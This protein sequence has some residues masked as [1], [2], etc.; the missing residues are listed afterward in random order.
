M[1]SFTISGRT[2]AN[3]ATFRA[4]LVTEESAA[5]NLSRASLTLFLTPDA[6]LS[7]TASLRV[8]LGDVSLSRRS[9]IFGGAGAEV[10]LASMSAVVIPHGIDGSATVS[11]SLSLTV[12]GAAYAFTREV[13][14]P[15]IDRASRLTS[16]RALTL[17]ETLRVELE[18]AER[19][20]SHVLLLSLGDE[21]LEWQLPPL[22]E[23]E[24]QDSGGRIRVT[25]TVPLALATGLTDA[26]KGEGTL[27]LY[28]HYGNAD[29]GTVQYEP[30]T[31]TV[32][33][34][35]ETIPDISLTAA[36]EGAP[37]A[38]SGL[39]IEGKTRVRTGITASGKLGATVTT[40]LLL[41]GVPIPTPELFDTPTGGTHTLTARATD[42]RGL[43]AETSHTL[44]VLGYAPPRILPVASRDRVV[45]AREGETALFLAAKGQ[46]VAIAGNEVAL[47]YRITPVTGGE[48]G[49]FVLLGDEVEG[50]LPDVTLARDQSYRVELLATDTLGGSTARV[51][52][53]S[54]AEV[55]LHLREGGMGAA[56]GK[57]AEGARVLEIAPD[58]TLRV[59]GELDDTVEESTPAALAAD[60]YHRVSLT[61]GRRVTLSLRAPFTGAPAL[62]H[63]AAVSASSAP[64]ADVFGVGVGENGAL[65]SVKLDTVGALF[66]LACFGEAPSTVTVHLTFEKERSSH[67]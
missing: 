55:T 23:E 17:G 53:V 7:G 26:Q 35:A 54:T 45:A 42:S 39:F 52:H 61:G 18:A 38:F 14:L 22:T 57:Y 58:W 15:V 34:L 65:V 2:D 63:G 64:S 51:L 66:A 44:T 4:L 29:I 47:S 62:L 40:S 67:D 30:I 49:E 46:A 33:E 28:T 20:F 27:T 5:E 32:P 25:K 13:A 11:L 36:P 3:N 37:E 6:T 19:A 9:E 16:S 21:E 59:H 48:N 12:G 43:T 50:V 24:W 60:C 10:E 1:A 41:D 56:F 31:V 8:A